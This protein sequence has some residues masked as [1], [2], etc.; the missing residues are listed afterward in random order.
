MATPKSKDTTLEV[1]RVEVM[2][3]N[4]DY[5]VTLKVDVDD[6]HIVIEGNW[7]DMDIVQLAEL[8]DK[9]KDEIMRV[10]K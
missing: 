4:V 10:V 8:L 7:R 2:Y 6:G 3:E 9:I 5:E 1:G